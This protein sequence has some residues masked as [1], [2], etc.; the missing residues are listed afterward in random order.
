MDFVVELVVQ[1]VFEF[2]VEVLANLGIT[3]ARAVWRN[4]LGRAL[5][6]G[7]AG[8]AF[9][10]WWAE[11]L[12]GA[13]RTTY[14]NLLGVSLLFAAAALLCAGYRR[15][16]DREQAAMDPEPY[17]DG[18]IP[19]RWSPGRWLAAFGLNL[20]LAAGVLAFFDKV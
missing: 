4:V 8:F 18:L 20:G 13:G 10:A 6:H 7:A 19:W 14:P 15:L 9:G 3:G 17:P 5:V 1:L 16:R 12:E 2:V 11:R